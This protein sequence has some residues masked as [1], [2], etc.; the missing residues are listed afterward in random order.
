MHASIA[1]LSL[2][3]TCV[4]HAMDKGRDERV[5][6]WSGISDGVVDTEG[7]QG[8]HGGSGAASIFLCTSIRGLPRLSARCLD[9]V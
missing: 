3:L 8:D 1:F 7:G 9:D 6:E 5:G 4:T 2:V